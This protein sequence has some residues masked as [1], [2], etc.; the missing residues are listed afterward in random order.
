MF[1]KWRTGRSVPPASRTFNSRFPLL[2]FSGFRLFY[3]YYCKILRHIA[4][5][6]SIFPFSHLLGNLASLPF[7]SAP[8]VPLPLPFL[9]APR[10]PVHLAPCPPVILS[11]VP[12]FPCSLCP[13]LTTFLMSLLIY[14]FLCSCIMGILRPVYTGDFCRA[15]R[16]NFCAPKLHQVSNMFET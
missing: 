10:P 5:F 3:H 6:F 15:T 7:F 9:P 4:L 16:C 14:L 12:L 11:S 2:S 8:P 13:L 1:F